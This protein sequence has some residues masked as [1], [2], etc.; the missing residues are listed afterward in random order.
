VVFV[1]LH[2]L[3]RRISNVF[4]VGIDSAGVVR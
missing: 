4:F 3:T 2:G 1:K